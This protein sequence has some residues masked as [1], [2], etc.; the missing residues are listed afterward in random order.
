MVGFLAYTQQ[1]VGKIY[2]NEFN[3]AKGEQGNGIGRKVMEHFLLSVDE[4]RNENQKVVIKL[5]VD[6]IESKIAH[7]FYQRCGFVDRTE[8]G[9][10]TTKYVKMTK[11]IEGP[12]GA[13]NEYCSRRAVPTG[14]VK[15]QRARSDKELVEPVE[16][17]DLEKEEVM[18]DDNSDVS[19]DC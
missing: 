17:I 7:E 14:R 10:S 4:N 2:V 3:V 9:D 8:A 13:K 1:T 16:E 5:R 6:K 11:T 18:F 15:L 12:V 19:L